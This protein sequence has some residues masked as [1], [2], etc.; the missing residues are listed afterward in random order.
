MAD[1][2]LRLV[3][4]STSPEVGKEQRSEWGL[5]NA[6]QLSLFEDLESIQILLIPVAD[7]S[8]HS[9]RKTLEVRSPKLIIDTRSF[10]DFFSIFTS[11]DG[12]MR[13]FRNRGIEYCRIPLSPSAPDLGEWSHLKL[14][15]SQLGSYFSRHTGA[16]V[17]VLSSTR[18]NSS[19]LV[20]KLEGYLS[21]E[22]AKSRFEELSG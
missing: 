9:F 2:R 18:K 4:S 11:V 16:P 13:E 17:V 1:R 22:V 6:K 21:Q 7:V 20:A 15:T 10:P 14:F 12:A 5:E 3:Y 19:K 8:S